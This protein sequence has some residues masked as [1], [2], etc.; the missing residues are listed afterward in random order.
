VSCLDTCA[1]N[2]GAALFP[3]RTLVSFAVSS[4]VA[5]GAVFLSPCRAA[6]ADAEPCVPPADAVALVQPELA[7]WSCVLKLRALEGELDTRQ[8]QNV[9]AQKELR[10]ALDPAEAL[11]ARSEEELALARVL[12]AQCARAGDA[13][14]AA[15]FENDARGAQR[16]L[17]SARERLQEERATGWPQKYA[18]ITARELADT[19]RTREAL[20]AYTHA[21]YGVLWVLLSKMPKYVLSDEAL[22]EKA[23]AWNAGKA[24]VAR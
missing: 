1:P 5:A 23:R 9:Y 20:L 15:E 6:D 7:P 10:K 13:A 22:R 3:R 4:V 19:E 14:S 17:A 11:V 18:D 8:R 12:A 21:R 2:C 24:Q 16:T